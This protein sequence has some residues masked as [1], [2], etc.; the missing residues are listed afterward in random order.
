MPRSL[1]IDYP[2]AWH[3]VMNRGAARQTIFH[4]D[5]D[6]TLFCACLDEA[7]ALAQI[8]LHCFCLMG[9][10]YHL[11]VRSVDARLAE[12]MKRLAGKFTNVANKRDGVDGARFRGRYMSVLIRNDAQLMQVS[13][14]IHLN[15]VEAG[16]VPRPGDWKWS[17]YA[18]Y[19]GQPCG[20]VQ[21]RSDVILDMIGAQAAPETYQRFVAEGI[22]DETRAYYLGLAS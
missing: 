21:M 14:Y 8:E 2:G 1:R 17:S 20:L 19:V 13:R 7:F 10:H 4:T 11:L 18:D 15:P 9:N 12:G 22:D 16:I 6:R 3:H 5:A